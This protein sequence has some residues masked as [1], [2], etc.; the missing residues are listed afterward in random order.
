MVIL[1][2]VL[3]VV[4]TLGVG[5]AIAAFVFFPTVAMPIAK[6]VVE[7]VLSCKPCLWVALVVAVAI[8]CFWYGRDGEYDKGHIAAVAEIAAEDEKAVA[9]A[10]AKRTEWEECRQSN[11]AWDQSRGECK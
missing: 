1:T 4:G 5:G 6:G 3:G 8:G 7:V 9:N 11:G 2:W 10:L